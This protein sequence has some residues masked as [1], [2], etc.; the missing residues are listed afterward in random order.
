VDALVDANAV[1]VLTKC[2]PPTALDFLNK[3]TLRRLRV[4][5]ARKLH[6]EQRSPAVRMQALELLFVAEAYD[7]LAELLI[8]MLCD[9]L[10][11]SAVANPILGEQ[12]GAAFGPGGPVAQD[13]TTEALEEQLRKDARDFLQTRGFKDAA[14]TKHQARVLELVLQVAEVQYAAA[15][16]RQQRAGAEAQ[17]VLATTLSVAEGVTLGLVP[18]CIGANFHF[19]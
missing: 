13:P 5:A 14:E 7:V 2:A 1:H 10:L 19:L 3:P 9:A 8:E 6:R 18:W 15:A 12:G 11:G 16:W 4:E 17:T